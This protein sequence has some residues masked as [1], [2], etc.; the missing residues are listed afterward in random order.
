M[1]DIDLLEREPRDLEPGG[2]EYEVRITEYPFT[3]EDLK[4]WQARCEIGGMQIPALREVS[5]EMKNAVMLSI[6]VAD[7]GR[8]PHRD[9]VRAENPA[10]LV[11]SM[12][13]AVAKDAFSGFFAKR[14]AAWL[15]RLKQETPEAKRERQ[16]EQMRKFLGQQ[17]TQES[18]EQAVLLYLG[19]RSYERADIAQVVNEIEK[20]RSW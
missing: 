5:D 6:W 3:L 15:E 16:R 4:R 19:D 9:L 7:R 18:F 11:V 10:T 20:K 14:L 1:F 13:T 8:I 12:I 17:K 2:V